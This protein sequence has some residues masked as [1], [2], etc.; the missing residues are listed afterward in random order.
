MLDRLS[1]ADRIRAAS[2][3]V[4]LI[5]T[6]LPWYRFDDGNHRV[7]ANAFGSGFLGDVVF[8]AAVASILSLL[9]KMGVMQLRTRF[10][11]DR[12][13]LPSGLVALGAVALQLLIGINGSGAFHHVT[14]GIVVA[15]FATFGMAAGA[16]LHR[17]DARRMRGLHGRR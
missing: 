5:A 2:S 16:M 12:V 7:T 17:Q 4:A 6:Y 3:V 11:D 8:F 13:G 1:Q 10:D 14:V 15:L 9:I